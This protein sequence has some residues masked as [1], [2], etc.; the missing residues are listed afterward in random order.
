MLTEAGGG[1][2]AP[3]CIFG[4]WRF[5]LSFWFLWKHL[6]EGFCGGLHGGS[7]EGGRVDA[8]LAVKHQWQVH[9]W[10]SLASLVAITIAA[11]SA[12]NSAACATVTGNVIGVRKAFRD[13]KGKCCFCL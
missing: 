4:G 1:A 7:L 11:L 8:G 6:L 3:V 2:V 13:E 9:G 10:H 12:M 5:L